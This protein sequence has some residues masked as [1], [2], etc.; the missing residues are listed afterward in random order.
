MVHTATG[1]ILHAYAVASGAG[2]GG[3]ATLD[4]QVVAALT[5]SHR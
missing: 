5:R 1:R 4:K 2:A 3:L